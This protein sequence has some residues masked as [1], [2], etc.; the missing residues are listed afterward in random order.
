VSAEDVLG[1]CHAL[2]AMARRLA[3]VAASRR[4]SDE[5]PRATSGSEAPPSTNGRPRALTGS[6]LR[7]PATT[8]L[9]VLELEQRSGDLVLTGVPGSKKRLV[10][11][12]AAGL[13]VGGHLGNVSLDP[14]ETLREALRWSGRR[15][16]FSASAPRDAPASARRLGPLLM[17]AMRSEP[18][19]ELSELNSPPPS[20]AAEGAPA[21]PTMASALA[22]PGR[23]SGVALRQTSGPL[24]RRSQPPSRRSAV[25]AQPEEDDDVLEAENWASDAA[26]S[27]T[28]EG[29]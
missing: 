12:M 20:L 9:A 14:V 26:A 24:R 1:Q 23:S 29:P 6:L 25:M 15:F 16:E 11:E 22:G 28:R 21:A 8:V 13:V 4:S 27:S 18:E 5:A 17:E 19:G 7:M 2:I 10:L 3:S